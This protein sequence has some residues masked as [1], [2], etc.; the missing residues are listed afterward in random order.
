[1]SATPVKLNDGLT[2]VITSQGDPNRDKL[3]ATSFSGRLLSDIEIV[4]AYETGWMAKRLVRGPARDAL[5]KWRVW[6]GTAKEVKPLE[7]T[8]RRLGMQDKLIQAYVLARILGGAA[9]Y[10]GTTDKDIS[11]PLDPS[12]MG[13]DGL[14]Y[15]NVLPRT[16]LTTGPLEKDV[17]SPYYSKPAYYEVKNTEGEKRTLI[18]PSRLVILIGDR[19]IDPWNAEGDTIGWGHSIIQSSYT[20]LKNSAATDDNVASLIFEANINIISIPDLMEKL[21]DATYE[22]QLKHRLALAAAQKGIHGDL[23]IDSEETFERAS[24]SFANLDAIMERYAVMVG[25]TQG[26]PASK[27]LGQMPKGIG[28]SSNGELTNY[29]DDIKTMQ[30]LDIQPALLILD[31]CLIRSS[32]GSRP[33][34]ISY[35]WA[36][37]SQPST[38]DLAEVGVKLSTMA[39]N[40]VDSGLYENSE[41]REAFTNQLVNFDLLPSLGDATISSDGELSDDFDLDDETYGLKLPKG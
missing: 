7:H 40:L 8:E 14:R 29:Y 2:S 34:D 27:F 19:H 15:L 22:K 28:S 11:K 26:I 13:K 5:S 10:I 25:A 39:K 21:G 9:L 36:P 37:L 1:M 4:R 41:L 24:A 30:S 6:Q 20:A 31:E 32:L 35:L 16:A 23:L 18:H 33:D 12:K 3:A 17:E 38:T